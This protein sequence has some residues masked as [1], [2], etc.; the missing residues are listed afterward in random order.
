MKEGEQLVLRIF[1]NYNNSL[2]LK[3][4][5]LFNVYLFVIL[6]AAFICYT[7]YIHYHY[8]NQTRNNL[9]SIAHSISLL[10][11]AEE[12]NSL[13]STD[14]EDNQEYM[15]IKNLLQSFKKSHPNIQY[16][17]TM[18]KTDIEN[19]CEFVVDAQESTSSDFSHIGD[20]YDIE[21][22]EEMKI[23]YIEP[24][25]DKEFETDQWGKTL[26]G[27][28]P[29]KDKFGNTVGIVG[30]D[31]KAE[32]LVASEIGIIVKL[33][34]IFLLIM[35][36]VLILVYYKIKKCFKP[37]DNIIEGINNLKTGVFNNEIVID[38]N[39]E[40]EEISS[41]LNNAAYCIEDYQEILKQNLLYEQEQIG[42]LK[43]VYRDVLYAV[44]QGKLNLKDYEDLIPIINEGQEL[45][46][47]KL[48]VSDD[49]SKIRNTV[50]DIMIKQNSSEEKIR[51]TSL[52]VSEAA[53]NALKHANGG[54]VTVK[55]V[56]ENTIRIIVCDHGSGMNLDDL[57]KKLFLKGYS[58]KNSLGFGFSIIYYYV[59]RMYISTSEDGTNVIM[60][61][62]ID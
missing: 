9:I 23:A 57:S 18:R 12:H 35:V 55:M 62:L 17:Y 4:F 15:K 7:L 48:E 36:L 30:V 5:K 14:D 46:N 26:S 27:Y 21:N 22:I 2:K 44:T 60:D 47:I 56:D 25:A 1:N 39:D 29:I 49:V 16:I 45:Q 52:C 51:H 40:L 11:D 37:I 8:K 61:F 54:L 58:T 32:T 3:F 38:T 10:I 28:A 20:K 43:K 42:K 50:T 59:D 41:A 24:T 34:I 31:I 19:E 53:T 13:K 6:I 33:S